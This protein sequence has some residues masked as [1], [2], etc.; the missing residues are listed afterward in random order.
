MLLRGASTAT[1]AGFGNPLVASVELAGAAAVSILS[2]L[3]P[4]LVAVVVLFA[5]IW[6][7]RRLWL[8]SQARG[9][10]PGHPSLS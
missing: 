1:T 5:L 10:A 8:R 2:L 9:T 3:A 6:I 7:A 4:V